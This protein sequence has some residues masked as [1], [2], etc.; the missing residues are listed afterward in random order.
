MKLKNKKLTFFLPLIA[1]PVFIWIVFSFVAGRDTSN[2]VTEEEQVE[3]RIY[4]EYIGYPDDN[5]N[6]EASAAF[7]LY[8]DDKGERIL[9]E[10]NAD[11]A[12]P[13]ASISKLMTALVVFENYN[14]DEAI[15]VT[16]YDVTSRT[17]FRDFRAWSETK[18]GEMIY[19]MLIES[20]N[21]AAFA[22]AL[23]SSR[24][25]KEEE[26]AVERFV[27]KMNAIAREIGLKETY[28]I[29]PSGLDGREQYNYSTARE[30]ALFSRY[31][32][33]NKKEI[34][35][36][37]NTP[38]YRLY[39]PDGMVYYE[40]LNT[41]VFLHTKE[42]DW[43]ERIIGGKTG[44]TRVAYGC[45]LLI[46]ESPEEEGYIINVVLGAEDRFREMEKLVNYVYNV[47]KF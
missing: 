3:E 4:P 44:W 15:R 31:L 38:S 20:N 28:F 41:N 18:I 11:E 37:T 19:P 14:L 5:A 45:L 30:I 46:L 29:N 23:I 27:K 39:S 6:L 22:L 43:Q 47:Y 13:I 24:F 36:I 2:T 8:Y 9:L 12:L 21:S 25:I 26:D 35:E 7:S 1:F 40:V 16:E 34:F 42:N 32:L 10:K 17:E 33:E